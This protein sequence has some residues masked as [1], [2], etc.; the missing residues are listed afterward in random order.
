MALGEGEAGS[1]GDVKGGKQVRLDGR[2][3]QT[4]VVSR[5][6]YPPTE[7]IGA[8]IDHKGARDVHHL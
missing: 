3:G 4:E 8:L 2:R 6:P 7:T 1:P 5:C